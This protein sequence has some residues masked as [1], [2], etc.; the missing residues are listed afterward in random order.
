MQ[1]MCSAATTITSRTP[2]CCARRFAI[3]PQRRHP[4][5]PVDDTAGVHLCRGL[6]AG[7]H[8][9]PQQQQGDAEQKYRIAA[10]ILHQ[11]AAH[12]CAAERAEELHTAVYAHRCTLRRQ[13]RGNADQRR[14]LGF[15]H[16]ERGEEYQQRDTDEPQACV[17]RTSAPAART[18]PMRWLA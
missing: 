10:H 17:E 3:L 15:Q 16:V 5:L 6:H 14:Q 2:F 1:T 12:R 18:A 4:W 13:R 8:Y 9:Q 11:R 7:G